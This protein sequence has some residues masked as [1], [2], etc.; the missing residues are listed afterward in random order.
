MV[1]RRL[2]VAGD[3]LEL[4]PEV[5]VRHHARLLPQP[6]QPH[7]PGPDA[8]HPDAEPDRGAEGDDLGFSRI[9]DSE[10]KAPIVLANMV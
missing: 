3:E 7:L 6:H 9:V 10:I 1:R 8:A 2:E 4:P 5:A